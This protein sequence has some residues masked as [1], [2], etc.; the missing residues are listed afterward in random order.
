[1]MKSILQKILVELALPLILFA[2]LYMASSNSQNFYFP[3]LSAVLKQF[4]TLW[5]GPRF[6][7]DVLPSLRRLM[8]GYSFSCATGIALG[9]AIGM[10]QPLRRAI[11]PVLEFFR[12]VPPVAMIPLLIVSMGFGDGMKITIIAAGAIWPI[13]LNTVEGVKAVDSVLDDTCRVYKI[14]GLARLRHFVI[15]S[16]SPQIIVG[17]RLGLSIGIVLM[18][19]SEMFAAL[20]GLG[21]AIIYFQRSYEIPS[22]WSGVLMLGIFGFTLS[23]VFRQ[24]ER[25]ALKWYYGM[26][27]LDRKN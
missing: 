23:V 17:M 25:W 7:S 11:E 3:P 13:L 16:A 9:I 2:L 15:P 1:M 24:F 8:L 10:S 27:E 21:S 26:R 18:V 20:D 22:M 6:F 4:D 14:S 12:A 5:F 19:I